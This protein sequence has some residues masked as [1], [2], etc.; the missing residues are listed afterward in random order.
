VGDFDRVVKFAAWRRHLA[1]V[2]LEIATTSAGMVVG[3]TIRTRRY[4]GVN[5]CLEEE[6][7]VERVL[8]R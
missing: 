1:A 6:V 8:T 5:E 7:V 3:I 4:A 2:L